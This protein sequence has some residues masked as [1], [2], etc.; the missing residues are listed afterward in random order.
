M[1]AKKKTKKVATKKTAKRKAPARKT[2]ARKTTARKTTARKTSAKRRPGPG[3][4]RKT[5]VAVL[6]AKHGQTPEEQERYRT[7]YLPLKKALSDAIF[8]NS[9]SAKAKLRNALGV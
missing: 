5:P 2:T 3:T 7:E 4:G 8:K 9:E 6:I 1:P